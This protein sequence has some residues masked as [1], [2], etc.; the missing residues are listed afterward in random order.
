M[1]QWEIT[2]VDPLQTG[3]LEAIASHCNSK[4]IVGRLDVGE[5]ARSDSNAG[6]AQMLRALEKVVNAMHTSFKRPEDIQTRFTG[7]VF[8]DLHTR[9]PPLICNELLKYVDSIGLD[10]FFEITPPS[11]LPE[12]Q[13]HEINMTLVRGLLCRNGSIMSNGD[14]RNYYQMSTLRPAINTLAMKYTKAD[15]IYMMWETID[16][17][18]RIEHAVVKRSFTWCTYQNCINWIGPC[19]AVTDADIA[20]THTLPGE[21]ISAFVW[22]KDEELIRTGDVWRF[23]DRICQEEVGDHSIYDSL[24]AVVP[25]LAAKLALMP[26]AGLSRAESAATMIDDLEWPPNSESPDPFSLS[27]Q[28]KD[29]TGLGC[30]PIGLNCSDVEFSD[31]VE[32]QRRLRDLEMLNPLKPEKLHNIGERLMSLYDPEDPWAASPDVQRAIRELIDLLMGVNGDDSDRIKV[33][34]GLDSG[35]RCNN[36]LESLFWGV[37]EVEA[38]SGH[39]DIFISQKAKDLPSTL[40]HTFMSCRGW[41]RS[42]CFMTEIAL[43]EQ[44]DTLNVDW[45]IPSRLVQDI[46]QLTPTEAM[47]FVRRLAL[48]SN[49]EC[50]VLS[51]RV[52][53]YCEHQL[54]EVPTIA[55]LRAL[56]ATAY[57]RGD[58]TAEDLINSRI[59]WYQQ[60]GC[61]YPDPASALSL[62]LEIDAVLPGVLIDQQADITAQIVTVLDTV[63]KKYYIDASAD[64]FALAI[65]CAFRRLAIQEVY[66]EVLDRNPLPNQHPDQAACFAEMFALGSR[67][68]SYF[69]MTPNV[70]G[71]LIADKQQAYYK[72]FQPPTPSDTSTEMPTAYSSK[73]VELNPHASREKVPMHYQVTFLGIFA[74]PALVDI[75]LLTTLGR[76]LYVT[77]YM[78]LEETSM[79]TTG[80]MVALFVTGAVGTWIGSGGSYYLHCMAFSAMNMFVLS[81]LVAGFAICFGGGLLAFI[82]IAATKSPYAGLIFM[83]Y[84]ILLS[85]YL[86][87][88]S[89]LSIYQMPGFMFQSVSFL[90]YLAAQ[91]YSLTVFQGPN[92]HHDVHANSPRLAYCNALVPPRYRRLC[93]RLD[94]V[95]VDAP[96]WSTTCNGSV[97]YVVP[98]YRTCFRQG[99]CNLV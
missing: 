92:C 39:I 53:S 43:A 67:C 94:R 20:T 95:R 44:T 41:T 83:L 37:Y 51:D 75:L 90:I 23:N 74:I 26:S 48:S 36:G 52:R 54:I 50:P 27:P 47:L 9:F 25:N 91:H 69:D 77:A 15:P 84:F 1:S 87:T 58:I 70:L 17:D 16:D 64:I 72:E 60:Q 30:F 38:G 81:R 2:V 31:V 85:M 45:L 97:G 5:I 65:F 7:V 8:A 61:R 18:V 55:Q 93:Y 21:P 33:Y 86:L 4:H 29:Y 19:A 80:L 13:C 35:F 3:V 99:A 98:S 89:A 63:I 71:R 14:R 40:L 11:F 76:G 24:K 42:Q 46:E 12:S 34:L 79:A 78:R 57:L 32:G 88:L 68:D 73:N 22:L 96:F 28:G 10:I 6:Q 49:P 59:A 82:I 56:N 66:L 62:F